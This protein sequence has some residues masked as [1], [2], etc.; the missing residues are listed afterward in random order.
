MNHLNSLIIEGNVVRQADLSE[1]AAGF[2]VCKFPV[3][4]N[5]WF[6][7]K[8]G[9]GVSEVSY[10][11][12]E[13]YGHMAEVCAKQAEKGR[14]VRVVGRLK[15]DRWKDN[16]D[17]TQTKIYIVA[18]HVEYKPKFQ[19]NDTEEKADAVKSGDNVK[20]E[21]AATEVKETSMEQQSETVEEAVF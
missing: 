8:D 21:T 3:A 15:Q 1:P 11:D 5:R 4:V 14:G 16:E 17:K 2:K 19:N 18:E 10:F 7:N 12:V 20:K 9:E 6:K 13:T